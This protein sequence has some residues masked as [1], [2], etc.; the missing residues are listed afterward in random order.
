MPATLY[1]V[2]HATPDWSRTDLRY[3]IPPGPPLTPQGEAEAVALGAFL[4]RVGI[5]RLYA[6]PLDRTLRTAAL[7]AQALDNL[8]PVTDDAIAEW[9]HGESEQQVL[10]RFRPR[11]HAAL[12]ESLRHGAVALV[13]HGGPIRLLLA[14]AGIDRQEIDYY[15]RMFDRDNPVPPAGVWRLQQ[16]HDGHW[17]KPELVHTPQPFQPYTPATVHL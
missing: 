1:L 13:T 14:E 17:L 12:D 11:I 8:I 16:N 7:A 2:R 4:Q 10:D 15:R 5:A 3:D 6:S 9:R